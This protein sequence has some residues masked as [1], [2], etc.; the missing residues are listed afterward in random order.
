MGMG[1]EERCGGYSETKRER[2]QERAEGGKTLKIEFLNFFH[3]G[4]EEEYE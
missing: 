4:K 2:G 3:S 1:N